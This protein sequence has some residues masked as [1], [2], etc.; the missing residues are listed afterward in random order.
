MYLIGPN[1]DTILH[2]SRPDEDLLENRQAYSIN[3]P[4][5]SCYLHYYQY[6]IEHRFISSIVF[7]K[8]QFTVGLHLD[9]KSVCV[10][11]CV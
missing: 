10:C 11:V 5:I 8:D 7:S 9:N 3:F 2:S 6:T 1:L 4:F